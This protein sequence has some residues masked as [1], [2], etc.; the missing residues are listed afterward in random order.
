MTQFLTRDGRSHKSILLSRVIG[1]APSH[2]ALCS[3][4]FRELWPREIPAERHSHLVPSLLA[5]TLL[6]APPSLH[7]RD[8]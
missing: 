6:T 2:G 7:P 1:A 5:H 4:P 3:D 8:Q